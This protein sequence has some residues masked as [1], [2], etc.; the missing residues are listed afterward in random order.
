V[1]ILVCTDGSIYSQKAIREAVNVAVKHEVTEVTLVFVYDTVPS[2]VFDYNGGSVRSEETRRVSIGNK[3]LQEAVAVFN[4]IE[5]DPHTILKKGH[6]S[7]EI[8][9]VIAE[10]SY[11]LVVVGCRG[12]SGLKKVFLGSV[13]NAVAQGAKCNVLIVKHWE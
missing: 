13:S 10:G 7:S 12:L 5:I 2:S 1:K 8:L 9:Q 3:V 4:E 11:D 6:P